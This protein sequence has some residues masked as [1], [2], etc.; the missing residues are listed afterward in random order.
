MILVV[1]MLLVGC[2]K[3][4]KTYYK[5]IYNQDWES[6]A[7]FNLLVLEYNSNDEIIKNNLINSISNGSYI[8]TAH[9][10]TEKCKIKMSIE[11]HDSI[12]T[13]DEFWIYQ[14]YYLIKND[15]TKIIINGDIITSYQEP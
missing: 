5:I 12:N 11:Y 3:E 10:N 13:K 2:K 8:Y 7:P 4:V 15:T 1:A 14:V 6:V 9:E